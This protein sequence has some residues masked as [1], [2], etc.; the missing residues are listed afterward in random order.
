MKR[1]IYLQFV[2]SSSTII[3]RSTGRDG[4]FSFGGHGNSYCGRVDQKM[5]RE[6]V[7]LQCSPVSLRLY[8]MVIYELMDLNDSLLY[9]LY[10]S[11]P[12]DDGAERIHQDD[13]FPPTALSEDI[14]GDKYQGAKREDV[15]HS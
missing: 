12:E 5:E 1:S 3:E 11:T 7:H 8:V 14:H 10:R 6:F 9:S 4:H 13:P 15:E 2:H